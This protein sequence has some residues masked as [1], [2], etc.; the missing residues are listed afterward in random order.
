[1]KSRRWN[2][3][4]RHLETIETPRL[5]FEYNI[6]YTSLKKTTERRNWLRVLYVIYEMICGIE[7]I[8]EL[9]PSR[10]LEVSK[11]FKKEQSYVDAEIIQAGAGVRQARKRE[12]IRRETRILNLLNESTTTNFEK[13]M[14]LA[15][16]ISLKS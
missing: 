9:Q 10:Y 13:V 12:Q 14:T 4:R 7:R 15:L 5:F 6:W 11:T 2:I 8:N 3:N 16:N 1:M